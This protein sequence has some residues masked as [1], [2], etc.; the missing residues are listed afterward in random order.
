MKS[1]NNAA[2]MTLHRCHGSGATSAPQPRL[3][4]T[5]HHLPPPHSPRQQFRHS[6]LH[7]SNLIHHSC[8]VIRI[9]QG[10]VI[11]RHQLCACLTAVY[12]LTL[13]SPSRAASTTQPH[14]LLAGIPLGPDTTLVTGPR[15]PDGTINY[16]AAANAQQSAFVRQDNAVK[17]FL[18][19]VPRGNPPYDIPAELYAN[20]EEPLPKS[21]AASYTMFGDW[22]SAIPTK[23]RWPE[24]LNGAT[25]Y[26]TWNTSLGR[27]AKTP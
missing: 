2:R 11:A 17:I 22:L 19:I 1:T 23:K 21:N 13:T 5:P 25:A 15:N 6:N 26:L 27:R 20:L 16:V 10:I 8:F 3:R 4:T 9:L 18:K 24:K 12:L 14:D 7:H